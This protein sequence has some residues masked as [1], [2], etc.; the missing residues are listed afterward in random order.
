VTT[1]LQ[2]A[3]QTPANDCELNPEKGALPSSTGHAARVLTGLC[4]ALVQNA[5]NAVAVFPRELREMS[6]QVKNVVTAR[7]GA[8]M[9][10]AAVGGYVFLRFVCPAMIAPERYKL[11]ADATSLSKDARRVLMSVSKVIQTLA[12]GI[13]SF[14]EEYMRP[15]D[16][17]LD[18]FGPKFASILDALAQEGGIPAPRELLPPAVEAPTPPALSP[19][20]QVRARDQQRCFFRPDSDI[21]APCNRRACSS[22][23]AA[24][25]AL[26]A[27]SSGPENAAIGCSACSAHTA[28]RR[29]SDCGSCSIQAAAAAAGGAEGLAVCDSPPSQAQHP[30][31]WL[32]HLCPRFSGGS[33]FAQKQC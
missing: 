9:G 24:S 3:E 10:L 17:F 28:S 8:K 6:C 19:R 20:P 21:G 32:C 13:T 33:C 23:V 31:N 15:M 29:W 26:I 25:T 14:K 5:A 1:Q 4:E 11:V 18:S 2:R 27:A 7:F 12:N 16:A 30:Q 22:A